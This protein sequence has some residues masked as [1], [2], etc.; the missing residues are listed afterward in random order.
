M[1]IVEIIAE[2]VEDFQPIC[3]GGASR[4]E[5]ISAMS[6]GG[7]THSHAT[8]RYFA[9]NSPIPVRAMIRPHAYGF[10]Y[11][12]LEFQLMLEDV[13][14][15]ATLPL[16]GIVIG[17]LDEEGRINEAQLTQACEAAGNL[18]ITFHR[19]I[20]DANNLVESIEILNRYPQV[21]T[22][23]T[24]GGPGVAPD[25]T[26]QIAEMIRAARP[27]LEILVGAGM[28]ATNVREVINATN[29]HAFHFGSA[30]RTGARV[31]AQKVSE[32]VVAVNR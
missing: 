4:I 28:N 6:E 20:D 7:L 14:Y 30:A 24:S 19:A 11:T 15:A 10:V 27:D 26:S 23:L 12:D 29:A 16:D 2:T 25:N 5:L 32:I 3:E 31:D 13:R 17:M 22:V 21:K 8:M 1:K 18:N 9:E